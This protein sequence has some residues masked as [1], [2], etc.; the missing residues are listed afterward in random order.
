M[1]DELFACQTLHIHHFNLQQDILFFF[2]RPLKGLFNKFVIER[3]AA[4]C[5]RR[6][7]FDLRGYFEKTNG[8]YFDFTITIHCKLVLWSLV[9]A[10]MEANINPT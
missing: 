8:T 4:T 2:K 6:V 1:A 7:F 3:T 10:R 9:P 5:S